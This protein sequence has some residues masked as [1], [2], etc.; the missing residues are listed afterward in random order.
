MGQSNK[1]Y[2]DVVQKRG[3]TKFASCGYHDRFDPFV[4][5]DNKR[6]CDLYGSL[7]RNFLSDIPCRRLLDMGC[8]TGIYFRLLAQ[9][10]D[11]IEALD[12]SEDML[13][14]AREYCEK[15]GLKNIHLEMGSAEALPYDNA[16]FD[17]V[18]SL[19]LLH[20]VSDIDRTLS[21]VH[22]VLKRG[23]HFFVFEP[24]ICNP[25]MLLAHA[26]PP[27]ERLA[28]SRNRPGKLIS[29]VESRFDSLKWDGVCELITQSTGAKGLL[30][31]V[32]LKTWK[33]TGLRRLFPRQAWLGRKV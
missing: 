16:S 8:G 33:V 18:M 10:A 9:Y 11:E 13:S 31:D 14:V 19:D 17:V 32:Y 7:F 2:R 21:E 24:N 29:L 30:L 20:H 4:L 25:L 1:H 22:R 5:N 23:G 6:I 26:I 15:T 12:Y 3:R 27:E 28:L